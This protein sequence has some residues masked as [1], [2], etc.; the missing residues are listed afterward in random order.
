[1]RVRSVRK[2]LKVWLAGNWAQYRICIPF[3]IKERNELCFELLFGVFG[4]WDNLNW[5][6]LLTLKLINSLKL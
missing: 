5:S 4:R 1:M 3:P 6:N 2:V